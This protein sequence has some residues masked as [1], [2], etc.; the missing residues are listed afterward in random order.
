M[1]EILNKKYA[2]LLVKVG[3]NL[4][5]GQSLHINANIDCYDLVRAVCK[6]AY[7]EGAK[8][9]MVDWRD[10][11]VTKEKFLYEKEETLRVKEHELSKMQ[12]ILDN[13]FCNLSISSPIPEIFSGIDMKEVNAAEAYSAKKTKH[14][15]DAF[16]NSEKQWCVCAYPNKI[17]AKKAFPDFE[18]DEAYK[19]LYEAILNASHVSLDNDPI[20]DWEQLNK[21]FLEKSKTL[22]DYNFK[23][24]HFKNNKG[25]DLHIGLVKNH[26]WAGGG[27]YSAKG[28][29]FNPNIPTEEIFTMPNNKEINGIVYATKPLEYNGVLIEDFWIRFEN[30]RVKEFDA[31]KNKKALEELINFDE[32]SNSLG[33]VAIVPHYS[34]I[35]LSNILFYN[36]LF[37][38]NA[39]CHLALG[40]SY[41]ATNLKDGTKYTDE[42][43]AEIGANQSSEHEDFMFGS[44]DMMIVGKTYDDKD[45]VI[46]KDGKFVI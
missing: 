7:S 28:I 29:Y 3:V 32:G 11:F 44:A 40:A 1:N 10:A 19:A 14:F 13:D 37:D 16:M 23:S 21:D 41:L 9:V 5:P 33:E 36:T 39:S 27:E 38:E 46:F 20:K 42:E 2:E 6:V 4:K 8:E 34:P 12:Y 35:S 25:T 24:L 31:L 26:I 15:Q 30:G 45:V 22:N 43:L 18:E 17:W